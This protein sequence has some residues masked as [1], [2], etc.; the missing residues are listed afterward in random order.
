MAITSTQNNGIE[1][2]RMASGALL[3]SGASPDAVVLT[4][5][6]TPRYV[7]C[8]NQTTIQV[9]EWFQGMGDADAIK[10][11]NHDTAQLSKLTTGGITV[12]GRTVTL[13]T[14]AQNDQ[15]WWVAMG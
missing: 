7:K 8:V 5:G 15:L 14:P 1:I 6:F 3:D 10:Q 13:A 9:Q 4:L 11:V 12:D 2:T